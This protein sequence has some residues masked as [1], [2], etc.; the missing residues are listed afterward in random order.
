MHFA[1]AYSRERANVLLAGRRRSITLEEYAEL[2]ARCTVSAAYAPEFVQF[3][4]SRLG[5]RP[6]LVGVLDRYGTLVAAFPSLYRMVFPT[7]FHRKL[8]GKSAARL[9]DFGQP[10]SLFPILPEAGRVTLG[11]LSPTTSVLLAGRINAVG[12]RSLRLVAIATDR[13]HKKLSARAR[14]FAA[15]GGQAH[16]TDEISPAEFAEAYVDLHCRRWGYPR[17][18][19]LPV[20]E[21]I[22][23]LYPHVHGVLLTMRGR[24][25]AV[26]L[27]WR[28]VGPKLY[29][30]DFI[31]AGVERTDD[32]TI[33][34]GSVMMLLS[35]RR[36]QEQAKARGCVLRFSFGYLSSDNAYKA[37]WTDPEP[38]FIGI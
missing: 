15:E 29:Y 4:F 21:Q 9:G 31:N 18:H 26:Q 16:F 5:L 33:S 1:W 32:N 11:H 2:C 24:P 36:T 23:A 38:T 27:C 35:L 8:L 3:Y 37:V 20:R 6:Q 34:Y 25:V 13:R 10:E 17:S 30:V 14:A 22:V 7:H 19:L 28:H 12:Q